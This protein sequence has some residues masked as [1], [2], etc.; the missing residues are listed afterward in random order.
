MPT[1]HPQPRLLFAFLLLLLTACSRD[2]AHPS[3][4]LY[5]LSPHGNDIRRE[6]SAA[7]ERWHRQHYGDTVSVQWVDIGGGGTGTLAKYL[8]T[9][10]QSSDTADVDLVFGGGSAQFTQYA[11]AGFLVPIPPLA[12]NDP[13]FQQDPLD[14]V[15]PDLF[16][17]PL[18]HPGNLW[19]A[20]TMASFGIEINKDR[21]AELGLP[22][23]RRWEDI[24]TAQWIGHLSLADPS[25]SGSVR[26]SYEQ[27]LQQHG[28]EKGWA[29][30][31]RIFANADLIRDGGSNPAED[32]GSAE[33][34]A[35]IVI[36][37]YGRIHITRAGSSILG[38]VIPD[39]GSALDPDPIAVLKGAPS[40]ELAAR[41]IRFTVSP[42]GQRLWT[43]KPGLDP[44]VGGPRKAA[45]GRLAV[46]PS[47]YQTEPQH[48]LEPASPFTLDGPARPLITN[49]RA[50]S[51]R[52]KFIGDL[53]KCTLV[54]NH[55]LLAR[56]RRA[57]AAA[58]DPPHLLAALD[59][60]PTFLTSTISQGILIRSE[61]PKPITDALQAAVAEEFAPTTPAR[62]THLEK[63]QTH[64]RHHWRD[65]YKSRLE[66]LLRQANAATHP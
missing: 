34:V 64:Q 29:L 11:N 3:Q 62:L 2:S 27:V 24:A 7:F 41:F 47:L 17:Q 8:E 58:G 36:D 56:T 25:K 10:F 65:S 55:E 61:A 53:I 52:N 28:W 23:P 9:R 5:I 51:I 26:S 43:F 42:A 22:T 37:F 15:P 1:L 59:A 14:R 16:G 20:A 19:I 6:F 31:T 60:P 45:L 50:L 12:P 57:I 66:S 38:F 4:T 48:M 44:S 40:P 32:V 35:G 49:S 33:A 54:D 13:V 18:R 39:G 30:L 46:L 63:L 21:I